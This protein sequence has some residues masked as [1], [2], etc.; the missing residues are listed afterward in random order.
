[1]AVVGSHGAQ[2][3][4]KDPVLI[5]CPWSQSQ[6]RRANPPCPGP[7]HTCQV[8]LLVPVGS[9]SHTHPKD[10]VSGCR[11]PVEAGIAQGACGW[12]DLP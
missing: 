5:I 7:F 9:A 1:M 4:I 8:H 10:C 2:I 12:R 3:P 6:D 11:H